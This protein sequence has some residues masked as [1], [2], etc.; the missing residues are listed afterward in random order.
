MAGD[1]LCQSEISPVKIIR[2]LAI[3]EAKEHAVDHVQYDGGLMKTLFACLLFAV[4]LISCASGVQKMRKIDPGMNVIE[5]NQIMGRR[6]SFRSVEYKGNVYTLYQYTNQYCNAH[7]SLY[8]KCD[9][10]VIFKNGKVIETGVREVRSQMPNMQFLYLF[11][12]TG[13]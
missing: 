7:V 6:D 3:C 10:F 2:Y 1:I 8:D 5:V 9:F 4:L 13:Q 12:M 11:N